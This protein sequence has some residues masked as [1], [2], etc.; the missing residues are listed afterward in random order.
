METAEERNKRLDRLKNKTTADEEESIRVK[1]AVNKINDERLLQPIKFLL[2][3]LEET[4]GRVKELERRLGFIQKHP[5]SLFRL[6]VV[7]PDFYKKLEEKK[8]K[9]S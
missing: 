7:R 3:K 4:E 1:I 6:H 9:G 2:K 8:G 5:D